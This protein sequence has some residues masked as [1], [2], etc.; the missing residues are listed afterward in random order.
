[1]KNL[2][3]LFFFLLFGMSSVTLFSQDVR[4]VDIPPFKKVSVSSG[5]DL[6]LSSASKVGLT[7]KGEKGVISRVQC[8]VVGDHL[9]ISMQGSFNWMSNKSVEVYLDYTELD[10]LS[11]SAGSDVRSESVLSTPMLEVKGSSG[12]DVYLMLD[13]QVLKVSLSSGA[14][15]QFKGQADEL[16]ANISSGS[17]LKAFELKVRKAS[18]EAS[19][20]ADAD[21][22][23]TGEI[24][25]RASGGSDIRYKGSP[26]IKD[27]SSSGGGDVTGY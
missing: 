8:K 21:V 25:A 18:V 3:L 1:M 17:D 22:F 11:A 10:Y 19:G 12:S 7:I 6:F 16:K 2:H 20:G 15:G 26:A 5:I 4:Q 13:V 24:Y 9:T 14:D 27:V 23:V